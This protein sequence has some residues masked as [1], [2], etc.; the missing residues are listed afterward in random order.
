MHYNPIINKAIYANGDTGNLETFI[1]DV[2]KLVEIV[3]SDGTY[4]R[5]R[6]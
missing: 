4:K 6:L 5:L 1:V 2:T 3:S